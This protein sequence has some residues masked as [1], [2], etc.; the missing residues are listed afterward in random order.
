[1]LIHEAQKQPKYFHQKVKFC[2]L[3]TE[4]GEQGP[5]QEFGA[6][7]DWMPRRP[8]MSGAMSIV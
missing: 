5:V 3:A 4:L 1:M 8:A 2:S 6:L 7:V